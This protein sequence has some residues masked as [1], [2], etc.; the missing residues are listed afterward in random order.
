MRSAE[1]IAWAH[2]GDASSTG[3][4]S[5]QVWSFQLIKSAKGI[6]LAIVC[7]SASVV[8][9]SASFGACQEQY[10]DSGSK[11][12]ATVSFKNDVAPIIVA[13]CGKCHVSSS[14]G[15]YGIESYDALMNSDS[16]TPNDPA[17]SNFIEVIES[18]DMPKGGLKVSDSELETLKK[19]VAQGAKFDGDDEKKPFIKPGTGGSKQAGRGRAGRGGGRLQAV[20]QNPQ[21]VGAEGVAW[22]ST[23][24]TAVAEAKRSN[25]PIFFMSAAAQCSGVS[26]V[27]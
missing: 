2:F 24:D 7:L 6:F 21:A 19:W 17:D 27:F 14:K 1:Y 10:E 5:F 25:R 13:K 9:A 23:W 15:K 22:Y 11:A 20:E 3:K 12:S 8:C 18:G 26:G 4:C 16:V